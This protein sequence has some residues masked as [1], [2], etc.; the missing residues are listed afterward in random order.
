[1]S[2][3]Q[4]VLYAVLQGLTDFLPLPADAHF[5]LLSKLVGWEKPDRGLMLAMQAGALAAVVCYYLADLVK[6]AFYVV[7]AA[8]KRRVG[9]VAKIGMC[10]IVATIPAAATWLIVECF[11]PANSCSPI[12]AGWGCIACG[13]ALAASSYVN[14]HLVWQNILKVEG[15]RHDSLRHLSFQ[16][17]F[18]V[19]IAQAL[20]FIPGVSR[21]AF[22]LSGGLFI[23]L[24]PAAAARLSFLL[25]IPVLTTSIVIESFQLI[26]ETTVFFEW[27]DMLL[28]TF[29]TFVISLASVHFFLRYVSKT[30]I[31]F[32]E[33][34]CIVLGLM[35][36][37]ALF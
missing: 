22:A 1:M 17:A 18:I 31:K 7:D 6:I 34:Y 25:A 19:G 8:V 13:I 30:G 20:M 21:S 26:E 5:L 28:A 29:S 24:R 35:F 37:F 33:G 36:L 32:F 11:L 16:Q 23:G 3:S 10:L 9:P 4:I 12:M 15:E 14:R 2:L 27:P